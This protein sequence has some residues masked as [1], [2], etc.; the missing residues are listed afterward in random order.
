MF[1][2]FAVMRLAL[3]C[4]GALLWL[5]LAFV[6]CCSHAASAA[7]AVPLLVAAGTTDPLTAAGLAG[8]SLALQ[9]AASERWLPLNTS[10]APRVL[11]PAAP[12]WASGPERVVGAVLLSPP[13]AGFSAAQTLSLFGVPQDGSVPVLGWFGRRPAGAG[14]LWL[15]PDMA[16]ASELLADVAA[17]LHWPLVVV[18]SSAEMSAGGAVAS[19]CSELIAA[20]S[21]RAAAL[22]VSVAAAEELPLLNASSPPA[23]LANLLEAKLTPLGARIVVA[24]LPRA[25]LQACQTAL[26]AVPALARLLWLTP[27]SLPPLLPGPPPTAAPVPMTLSLLPRMA[28]SAERFAAAVAAATRGTG[29]GDDDSAAGNG[30]V[31]AQLAYSAVASLLHAANAT[32]STGSQALNASSVALRAVAFPALAGWPTPTVR[33]RKSV[34]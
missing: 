12:P 3:A 14:A 17:A 28:R 2:T 25:V 15:T 8:A 18:L 19:C 22:N 24:F 32:L 4:R 7:L 27:S 11:F 20:F 5:F 31:V 1:C 9:D 16:A 23:V 26:A 30:A 34:V 29:A 6:P 10:V 33:D 13:S 21:A